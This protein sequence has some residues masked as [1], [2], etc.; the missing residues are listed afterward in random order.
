LSSDFSHKKGKS[1]RRIHEHDEYDFEDPFIDDSEQ[2]ADMYTVRTKETG[3]FVY[4]G[5]VETEVLD[6]FKNSRLDK[7]P[8]TKNNDQPSSTTKPLKIQD[9]KVSTNPK[10]S[11]IKPRQPDFNKK[12]KLPDS[13]PRSTDK[14]VSVRSKKAGEKKRKDDGKKFECL[15]EIYRH[16]SSRPITGTEFFYCFF[17][18]FSAHSKTDYFESNFN[19][20]C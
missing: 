16:H 3:F 5:A 20:S 13:E 18:A 2:I 4:K 10:K 17:C 15:S 9:S 1:V 14:P 8:V 12:S 19:D 6:E 7:Q 11:I